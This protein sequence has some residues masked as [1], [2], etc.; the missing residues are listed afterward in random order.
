MIPFFAAGIIAIFCYLLSRI[1]DYSHYGFNE[2][3]I[4]IGTKKVVTINYKNIK[5]IDRNPFITC[6]INS[7]SFITYDI[8]YL[9]ETG[10]E[11]KFSF[12]RASTLRNIKK[13]KKFKE[14]LL[15]VNPS[16]VINEFLL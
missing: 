12:R 1:E 14:T 10:N 3:A 9:N 4:F 6:E 7:T 13:W 11:V 2:E 8:Y 15:C 5:V 16:V